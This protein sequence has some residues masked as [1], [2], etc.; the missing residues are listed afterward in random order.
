LLHERAVADARSNLFEEK[1]EVEWLVD[2][3]NAVAGANLRMSGDDHGMGAL[4]QTAPRRFLD[5]PGARTA[6]HCVI[7][8]HELVLVLAKKPQALV[9]AGCLIYFVSFDLERRPYHPTDV[10]LI[11]DHKDPCS[12]ISGR[13]YSASVGILTAAW[14]RSRLRPFPIVVCFFTGIHNCGPAPVR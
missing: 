14:D 2:H 11:F 12:R 8:E 10:I 4:H 7:A 13:G 3:D 1:V 6:G 5:H 9:G